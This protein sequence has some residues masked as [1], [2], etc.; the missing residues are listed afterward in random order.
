VFPRKWNSEFIDAPIVEKQKQPTVTAEQI[1]QAITRATEADAVLFILSGLRI[2]EALALRIGPS[3]TSSYFSDAAVTVH[4][5]L[6][7]RREQDP[8]KQFR[9]YPR[10]H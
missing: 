7:R 3:E 2:G 8:L 10:P 6:W 1:E 4:T 9:R 5:S